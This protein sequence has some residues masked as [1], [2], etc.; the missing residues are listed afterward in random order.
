MEGS[1]GAEAAAGELVM[2]LGAGRGCVGA[3]DTAMH[4]AMGAMPVTARIT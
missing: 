1:E 2:P 3:H 4:A